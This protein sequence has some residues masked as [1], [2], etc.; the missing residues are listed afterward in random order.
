MNIPPICERFESLRGHNVKVEYYDPD[1]KKPQTVNGVASGII[2]KDPVKAI[3]Q[4]KNGNPWQIPAAYIAK[5]HD[6]DE[7]KVPEIVRE[8][9]P[10]PE[11]EQE[12]QL[13]YPGHET[14]LPGEE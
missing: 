3:I 13:E 12:E 14:E 10:E 5:V 8:P 7:P 2:R 1:K 9:A 4:P 11:P 6:L